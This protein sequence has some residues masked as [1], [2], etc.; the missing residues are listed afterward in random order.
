MSQLH[1]IWDI[2]IDKWPGCFNGEE[3]SY[4]KAYNICKGLGVIPLLQIYCNQS[5]E[6]GNPIELFKEILHKSIVKEEDWL[7][8]G[9]FT[10]LSS[11]Q[12][13]TTIRKYI[14]GEIKSIY[15]E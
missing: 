3:R 6:I 14:C 4:D 10:G 11:G 8:G 9:N 1:D 2:V 7:V 13:K 12:G 15:E 5:N